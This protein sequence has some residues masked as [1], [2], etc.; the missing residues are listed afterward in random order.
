MS[1]SAYGS[2]E[3]VDRWWQ[4]AASP[5]SPPLLCAELQTTFYTL[6]EEGRKH[7]PVFKQLPTAMGVKSQTLVTIVERVSKRFGDRQ[8]GRQ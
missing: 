8:F 3:A 1:S 6:G 7:G 5:A 4:P 2:E